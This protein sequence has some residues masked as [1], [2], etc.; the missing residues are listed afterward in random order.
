MVLRDSRSVVTIMAS[1]LL[2]ILWILANMT[3][4]SYGASENSK[5][6]INEGIIDLLVKML[7]SDIEEVSSN[8]A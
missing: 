2:D 8:S 3:G 4:G 6:L 7:N 1:T 5:R